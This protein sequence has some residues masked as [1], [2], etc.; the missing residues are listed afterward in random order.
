V[1]VGRGTDIIK[2]KAERAPP[3]PSS[4]P[5][6]STAATG[7]RRPGEKSGGGLSYP[8]RRGFCAASRG[9]RSGPG[10]RGKEGVRGGSGTE[11]CHDDDDDGS[12]DGV[13]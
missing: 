4:Q 9:V 1:C 7:G 2:W 13:N 3:R 5:A 8:T 11:R 10:S 6:R 12:S